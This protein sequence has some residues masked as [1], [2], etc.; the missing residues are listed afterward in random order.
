MSFFVTRFRLWK[1]HR[2]LDLIPQPLKGRSV[3][4][5]VINGYIF[6][7]NNV[8]AYITVEHR[9]ADVLPPPSGCDAFIKPTHLCQLKEDQL[10]WSKAGNQD[11]VDIYAEDKQNLDVF[12]VDQ[13]GRWIQLPSEKGWGT[14]GGIARV[15]L[16][17]QKYTAKI[18]I[19]SKDTYAKEFDV[20]ID[21]G[22][23][24]DPLRRLQ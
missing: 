11:V 21:P 15:F 2:N 13:A 7:L 23:G 19:A 6:P 24:S 1:L 18:K 12:E 20:E 9:E 16:K 3:T 14:T 22:N 5:R 17:A 8:I 10:C 4:A